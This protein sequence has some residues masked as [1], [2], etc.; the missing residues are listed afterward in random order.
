MSWGALLMPHLILFLLQYNTLIDKIISETWLRARLREALFSVHSDIWFLGAVSYIKVNKWCG[1]T[2]LYGCMLDQTSWASRSHCVESQTHSCG[3]ETMSASLCSNIQV[4]KEQ[5]LKSYIIL[6]KSCCSDV[7]Q[8][9]DGVA[10]W[11]YVTAITHHN[12]TQGRKQSF[13]R[14]YTVPTR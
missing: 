2:A 1:C 5:V 7:R 9:I 12:E 6:Y 14:L 3:H 10:L 13:Q 4:A 11:H 8:N